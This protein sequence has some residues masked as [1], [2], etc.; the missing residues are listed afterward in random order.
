MYK[1]LLL[2]FFII[3]YIPFS[4][5]SV[6]EYYCLENNNS[7]YKSDI[8]FQF[9]NLTNLNEQNEIL[10]A[11][12]SLYEK[13]LVTG[14]SNWNDWFYAE[15]NNIVRPQFVWFSYEQIFSKTYNKKLK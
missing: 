13:D 5:A 3:S 7:D 10:S 12:V 6:E 2:V 14:S 8:R 1:F 9:E 15:S 11:W 4:Y